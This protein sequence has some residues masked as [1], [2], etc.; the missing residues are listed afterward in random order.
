MK[1][2]HRVK[3]FAAQEVRIVFIFF[4]YKNILGCVGRTHCMCISLLYY[5]WSLPVSLA[6]GLENVN[7]TVPG[8]VATSSFSFRI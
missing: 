6:F 3:T 4:H 7:V 8:A 2:I 5:G 1:R